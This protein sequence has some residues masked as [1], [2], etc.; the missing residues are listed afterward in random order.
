MTNRYRS[1]F[2]IIGPVMIGPSSSHTAGAVAIGHVANRLFHAPIQ[3]VVVRYFESFAQ[4][5][6][7]HGTDYAIISGVLGFDPAD[8]RVPMAVDL[9]RR[10]GI[11]IK[12][13]EDQHLSPIGHPNTAAVTLI[14]A[15]KEI[16]VWGCSVGGGTIEIRKVD[17]NGLVFA[18]Q[19]PLPILFVTA[20]Q[21]IGAAL[22]Q[23]FA[24]NYR[25]PRVTHRLADHYIYQLDLLDRPFPEQ[26]IQARGMSQDAILL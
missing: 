3:E 21:P 26:L 1:V 5:H 10:L 19:G 13:I 4:T 24:A 20:N 14:N 6:R 7:G 11:K 12:F 16:T 2:D 22:D 15:E 25:R 17:L 9:A 23:L 8:R 18:P